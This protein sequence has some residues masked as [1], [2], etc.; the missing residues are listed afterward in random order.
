MSSFMASTVVAPG[1]A[2][3]RRQAASRVPGSAYTAY[4]TV[5]TTS[6]RWL[7]RVWVVAVRLVAWSDL[8]LSAVLLAVGLVGTGPAAANQGQVAPLLS[9][10]LVAAAC[11][12]IAGLRR[13]PMWTYVLTGAATIV[14]LGLGYAYGPI[15]FAL[16][17]AVYGL[18]VRSP[19]RRT[20]VWVGA[21]L[22]AGIVTVILTSP[23]VWQ[24]LGTVAAWVVIPAAV[25]VAVKAR[26]DAT[27]GIRAE[28]ARRVVSEERL[29]LAQ[30]VH[31][32]VGHGLAVI[33]MQAGVAL[34][35]LDRDP[36]AGEVRESLDA[37]RSLARGTLDGLRTELESLRYYGPRAAP[38][39]PDSG[40]AD[41]PGLTERIRSA[42]LPVS[43]EVSPD[44]AELPSDVD[45]AVYRIV[46]ESLTNV[47]RHAG[48]EAAARVRVARDGRVLLVEVADSGSGVAPSVG[49][50]LGIEGMRERAE[51]LGGS[52]DAG[53]VPGGGFAVRARLP[54]G[55]AP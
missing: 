47:L 42:G 29:Q 28:Q 20:A 41:V 30:D 49:G 39:R 50:G 11:L 38:V 6:R 24:A 19:P 23:L 34:R 3:V 21:L 46:Q 43:V 45:R 27:S 4:V 32:V 55:E 15:L 10:I 36:A 22:G 13:R 53:P 17:V 35:V 33:A 40:L 51:A 31:D 18:A 14:Y 52:L 12:P 25:G 1:L 37:I 48:P 16:V 54:V 44:A 9:Y 8:A 2:V 5:L 26:R 7:P